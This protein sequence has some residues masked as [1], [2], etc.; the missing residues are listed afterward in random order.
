MHGVFAGLAGT[1]AG[2]QAYQQRQQQQRHHLEHE[3]SCGHGHVHGDV[4]APGQDGAGEV[5][6]T[7]SASPPART[8]SAVVPQVSVHAAT[9]PS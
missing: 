9:L 4:H 5:D 7:R 2:A 8:I 3:R 6:Q 1:A